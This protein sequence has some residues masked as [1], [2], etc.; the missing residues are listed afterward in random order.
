VLIGNADAV[1]GSATARSP[2]DR[3]ARG[4]RPGPTARRG[5]RRQRRMIQSVFEL[6]DSAQVMVHARDGVD[7]SDKTAGRRR[8]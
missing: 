7:R 1:A 3:A 8:R 4:R 6:G 5:G 2:R